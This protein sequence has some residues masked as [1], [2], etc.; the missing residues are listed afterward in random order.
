MAGTFGR[1]KG[2]NDF[3]RYFNIKIYTIYCIYCIC[4]K[5]ITLCNCLCSSS[6]PSSHFSASLLRNIEEFGAKKYFTDHRTTSTIHV[7]KDLV[8]VLKILGCY[9]DTQKFEQLSIPRDTRRLQ[10]V[11]VNNP[12]QAVFK[13]IYTVYTYSN[14][15]AK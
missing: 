13:C 15:V 1:K 3:F 4:V 11:H 10:C 8:P 2:I 9:Y 12:L 5:R 6:S 14:F 7:F